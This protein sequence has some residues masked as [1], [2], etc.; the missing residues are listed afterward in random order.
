MCLTCERRNP[1]FR[2]PVGYDSSEIRFPI[3]GLVVQ[4]FEEF[5]HIVLVGLLFSGITRRIYTGSSTKSRN[6]Q[7]RVFSEYSSS[8][9]L[10]DGN[11]LL[12]GIAFDGILGFSN[13]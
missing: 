3:I 6:N 11:D 9:K 10:G 13:F 5:G 1:S 4:S 12:N 7:P 2:I 8:G